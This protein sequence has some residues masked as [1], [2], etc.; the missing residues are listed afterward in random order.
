MNK[1]ITV[2]TD[3][4]DY[5]LVN[6]SQVMKIE[7]VMDGNGGCYVYFNTPGENERLKVNNEL[8]ELLR[9]LGITITPAVDSV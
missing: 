2:K 8:D 7:P 5:L 4:Y 3:K 1:F 9:M 6:L